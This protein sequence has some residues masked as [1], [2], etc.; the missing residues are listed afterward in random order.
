MNTNDLKDSKEYHL[1]YAELI[2]AARHRGTAT[3]QELAEL[4]GI[5]TFGSYMGREIGKYAGVISMNEVSHGRP[6]LSVLIV[7]V[8]GVP[9]VGF[10]DLAKQ[11]G[12]LDSDDDA[13]QQAFLEAETKAVYD[14][15]KRV[16]KAPQHS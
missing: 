7:R 6:M 14:T 8:D 15:W 4:I 2:Y 9:S 5:Q 3:Y 11:L 12:K 10:F 1:I 16:F 13:R